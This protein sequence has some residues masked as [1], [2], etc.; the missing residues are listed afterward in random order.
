MDEI[1]LGLGGNGE[2]QV[3]RLGR[4][5]RHGLIA[6]ATGT[7]KT[8]TLQTIAE[9]FSAAGVPVFLADVKGDLSGISMPGSPQF[10]N[11]AI[12]EGRA[13]EIGI[14]DYAYS[15]NPAVFWDIYGEQ[16]HPVRTTISEMGPLLLARLMD[17]NDTQEG[18]LNIV[19]RY[20][21][22][23]GLLLL[24]L[25]DLQAML[26]HV[27]ENA[28]ALSARYGNVTKASVGTIQRQVLALDSQ[29]AARFFGEPA[30][31]IADFIRCD[32]KGRGY[33]NVLAADKLMRSPKLYATFL[34]WLLSELFEVLPEV[35]DPD[36]PR[37]VFFFD[38]AH[39]LFDDAPKALQDKVEQVVRLV[40]SKG[41]GVY[42]VTQNPIDIPEDIAGQ[43][44][45]RVQ[46]ALRAFTPRDK[47]AIKAAADTFRINPA[48]DVEAAIT[49]LKV[50]EALVS[51]LDDEGAPTV[52]Q[53]TLIAPPRSRL[54]PIEAKERAIIQSVSPFD[55]KYDTPVNRESAEEILAAKAADAAA[56]AQEVA[57]KGKEEVGK[58]ERKSPSLWDGL[59][60]KV[61][62]A[63]A[64]AAA[65]S[66][67]SILAQSM[68]GRKS[69]ADPKASA[70][71]AAAGTVGDALGK[72][73]G[74]PGLGRFARNLI[75]GLMR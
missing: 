47:K 56:T 33:I 31:E 72:V 42:F 35:G 19:F 46:H 24:D 73:I 39:L 17:L 54:G 70:A 69:R 22:E 15:D 57:E 27:A 23:Q 5:N 2:R 32:D 20:A 10:K 53:R 14:T 48:L 30:L 38:E 11:A 37:L 41:V 6:G 26:A 62:K 8:V 4:A 71:S 75:G 68:Q 7:G 3:L 51:T 64:G 52:V 1:F 45:N 43:L 61:A 55:G 59:G 67:G 58:Q 12:L 9:Q 34:L 28:A 13:R 29:G 36:K 49:E 44:G 63:A 25:P 65:A 21:D 40:R 74:F 66:A 18:V 16:G 50:G 60:G